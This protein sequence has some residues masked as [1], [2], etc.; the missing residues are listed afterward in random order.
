MER[1]PYQDR[2]IQKETDFINPVEYI[3]YNP[4]KHGLLEAPKDWEH[5]SFHRYVREGTYDVGWGAR[6]EITFDSGT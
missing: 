4:V 6:K 3:H 2:R 5:S 1:H